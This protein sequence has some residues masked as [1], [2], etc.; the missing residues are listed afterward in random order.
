MVKVA[1]PLL[2]SAIEPSLSAQTRNTLA[3]ARNPQEWNAL[4]LASPEL[5]YR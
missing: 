5:N 1:T 4:L 3:Q 2:F